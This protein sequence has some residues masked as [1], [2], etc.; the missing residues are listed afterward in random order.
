M[1]KLK[2]KQDNGQITVESRLKRKEKINQQEID[3]LSSR[4]I[5]GIMRPTV[6]GKRKLNYAAPQGG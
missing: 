4:L 1:A 3:V 5:R 2:V 6:V